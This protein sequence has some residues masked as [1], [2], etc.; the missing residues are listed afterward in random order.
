MPQAT[1]FPSKGRNECQLGAEGAPETQPN[2][3]RSSMGCWGPGRTP[4]H[5]GTPRALRWDPVA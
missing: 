5:P 1:H 3:H 4:Q 2:T